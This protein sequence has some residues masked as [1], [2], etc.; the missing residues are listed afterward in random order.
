MEARTVHD[1]GLDGPRPDAG[2]SFLPDE[3]DG[4]RLRRGGGVCRQRL[5]LAPG[6]DLRQGRR[7]PRPCLGIGRP[8]KTP[9]VDVEPKRGKD[10]R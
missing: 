9:L 7:D 2:F 5:D 4:P 6:R 1:Q 3:L 10:L 8:H